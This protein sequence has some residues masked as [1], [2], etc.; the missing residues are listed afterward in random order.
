M[1][2]LK[3]AGTASVQE[4]SRYAD[5]G[6][7]Q[8]FDCIDFGLPTTY[9]SGRD[10]IA[11]IF[12]TALGHVLSLEADAILIEFGGDIFG[13]NVPVFLDCLKRHRP[14]MRIVLAASDAAAALGSKSVLDGMGLEVGFFTGPC[15]DTPT[16]RARTELLCGRPAMNLLGGNAGSAQAEPEA[17]TP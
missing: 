4:I 8:I 14:K 11:Q 9:P 2:A 3:G 1:V 7:R 17:S 6:A 5:Y 16:L 13:A 12:E 10:G 15:T